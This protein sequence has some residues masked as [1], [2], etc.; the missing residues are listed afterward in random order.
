[1]DTQPWDYW[2]AADTGLYNKIRHGLFGLFPAAV[3]EG[4]GRR[5]DVRREPSQKGDMRDTFADTAA[6]V[7][8]L[9][10]RSTVS[11]REGLGREW[12]WM[13]ELP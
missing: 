7:A 8:D 1:M 2:E 13:K 3:V 9:G 11:L 6:A 4:T 12:G 5:L 10:F